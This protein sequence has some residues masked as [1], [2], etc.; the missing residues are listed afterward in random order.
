MIDTSA[1]FLAPARFNR[2]SVPRL[3]SQPSSMA[4]TGQKTVAAM[5]PEVIDAQAIPEE[6]VITTPTKHSSAALWLPKPKKTGNVEM[7]ETAMATYQL[8]LAVVDEIVSDPSCVQP[9]WNKLQDRKR[10]SMTLGVAFDGSAK[11]K[12]AHPTLR[13]LVEEEPE[14]V[15][16][17]LSSASDCSCEEI[18]GT[19]KHDSESLHKLLHAS[20][21]LA[22]TLRLTENLLLK[23][24]LW[25]LFTSCSRVAGH[26]LKALK[27]DGIFNRSISRRCATISPS[28][29]VCWILSAIGARTSWPRSGHWV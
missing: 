27:K 4:P 14:W 16:F 24:V 19:V 13:K 5:K 9:L 25:Q 8:A 23:N 12:K 20:T 28:K 29:R 18:V 2:S 7:D 3:S 21:Q 26:K 15:V 10:K 11:F 6:P 1:A 22:G 17:Y